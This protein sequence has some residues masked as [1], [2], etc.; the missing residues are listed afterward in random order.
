MQSDQFIETSHIDLTEN[1]NK[2]LELKSVKIKVSHKIG[3]NIQIKNSFCCFDLK[4]D[5]CLFFIKN[6]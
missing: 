4:N 2:N 1:E 5:L 3:K 6:P